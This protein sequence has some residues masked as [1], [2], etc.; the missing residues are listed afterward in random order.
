MSETEFVI[1][2]SK[3]GR[4]GCKECKQKIDL[5]ALRIGKVSSR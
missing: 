2:H 3:T 4:A 1:E 5:G